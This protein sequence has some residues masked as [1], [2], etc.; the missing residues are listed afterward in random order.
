MPW[1]L[2]DHSIAIPI[3]C[4][5]E[6]AT[7]FRHERREYALHSSFRKGQPEM[8]SKMSMENVRSGGK[9]VQKSNVETDQAMSKI[10]AAGDVQQ[11][12]EVVKEIDQGR[13]EAELT[14]LHDELKKY[15]PSATAE[16]ERVK[17]AEAAAKRGDSS[18]VA[19]SLKGAARWVLEFAQKIGSTVIAKIIEKQM[20]F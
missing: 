16:L 13:L 9:V 8:N 10:D 20:G 1:L 5:P 4:V 17:N 6:A 14:K 7:A 11:L 3:C 15:D 2:A 19:S 18:G 12:I